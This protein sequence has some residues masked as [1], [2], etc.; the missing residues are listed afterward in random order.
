MEVSLAGSGDVVLNIDA[1]STKAS[2]AGSGDLTIKGKTNTLEAE[3]A[4]SGNFHGFGLV[5]NT[6]E[7]SVAGSGDADVVSN[8]SIKA[9]VS[10]SGDIRY[11][12]NPKKEDTKVAGSGSISN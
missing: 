10:G 2:L 9:R 6:T 8:E 11:K 12:G 4:G 5:A 3:V 1:S 7:V